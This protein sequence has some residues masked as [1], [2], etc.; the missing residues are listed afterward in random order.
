M[1]IL[2]FCV[3]IQEHW[4]RKGKLPNLALSYENDSYFGVLG[5]DDAGFSGLLKGRPFGVVA[6]SQS[7]SNC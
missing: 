7:T 2:W 6:I 4:L 3:A 5:I 1:K